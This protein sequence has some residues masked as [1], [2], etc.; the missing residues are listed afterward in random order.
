M[1][2]AAADAAKVGEGGGGDKIGD[3]DNN[4]V[5]ADASS[6]KGIAKGIKGIVDAAGKALGEGD[7]LKDVK[8]ADGDDDNKE[9]GKLFGTQAGG[10][11]GD[12]AKA[13]AA[14][15]AV[16]GEQ[17]L[18]AIVAAAAGEDQEGAAA[19]DAKNPIAAAI[20]A[21]GAAAEFGQ[22]D[23]KKND[24]IAA[25][26]VLRGVAKSG[27]FAVDGDGNDKAS[28][29]SA[30]ESAVQKTF[31][32]LTGV[33]RKAAEAGLKKVAEGGG[34]DKI[35]DA[36]NNGVQADA[37]SVKGI[38]KGI[39]GIVDAAGKA[40]GEGDA[41]KDVKEADGD[42]D[43]KEAGKLFGTQAGGNAG[44]GDI[45]KA[46]AAVSAVSGEQILKAIVAAALLV[47]IRRV[48]LLVM[49]RIRLRLRLGMVLL[50]SLVRR[51]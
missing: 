38:A 35:G 6:V 46:A 36:D 44:A 9:A 45:A 16:S 22:A 28:V 50:R 43:N 12:I 25:A 41:L 17:I 33:V 2:K 10:N 1:I 37:S 40:L 47:R 15:S 24:K 11:A 8:E 48:R 4:G 32:A 3:A 7:A 5:Q 29:K 51:I 23:M 26:I 39:K 42:D 21:A 31:A 27:K 13:A 20:G 30:V 18:K 19:G 49:L 14:V 34:G